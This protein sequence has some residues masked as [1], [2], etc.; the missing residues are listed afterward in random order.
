MHWGLCF[1]SAQRVFYKPLSAVYLAC[2]YCVDI[3]L[4]EEEIMYFLFQLKPRTSL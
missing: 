2:N 1:N 4:S 3:F